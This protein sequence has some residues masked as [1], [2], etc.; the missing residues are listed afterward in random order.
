MGRHRLLIFLE[1]DIWSHIWIYV[2]ITNSSQSF[3]H[4]PETSL[5]WCK[6]GYNSLIRVVGICVILPA[7]WERYKSF[8][9]YKFLFSFSLHLLASVTL[10]QCNSFLPEVNSYRVQIFHQSGSRTQ[11]GFDRIDLDLDHV[12]SGKKSEWLVSIWKTSRSCWK[13]LN[14]Q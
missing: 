12:S 9:S 11:T 6:I 14:S 2:S 1:A 3:S 13:L 10:K 5:F 7:I 8:W 4:H